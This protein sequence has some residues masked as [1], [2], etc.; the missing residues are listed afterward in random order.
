MN[1]RN[2]SETGLRIPTEDPQ[3]ALNFCRELTR[4]L[5]QNGFSRFGVHSGSEISPQPCLTLVIPVLNEAENLNAL[6][7]S[8]I[9]VLEGKKLSFEIIF[10]DDGST[11]AGPG[12]LAELSARDARVVVVELARNF[13]QQTAFSA[14]LSYARGQAVILMDA[15]LQDT[16]EAIPKF[17]E[18][19][20]EGYDVVYAVRVERKEPPVLRA[21]YMMFYRLLKLTSN[22]EIP[23]NA[24]DFCLM[25]QKVAQV[26][27]SMPERNRFVRGIRSWAGFRQTGINVE[28]RARFA[29]RPKYSIRGLTL[30]AIDGLVSFSLVP[31]RCISFMGLLVSVLALCL[32]VFYAVKK[33]LYGLHPYG[34]ATTVVLICFLAGVQLITIGVIGEYVGRIFVEVKQ[35][36]LFVVRRVIRAKEEEGAG[37]K[38]PGPQSGI[39]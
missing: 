24:G 3:A 23:L 39:S 20:R 21:A 29:G 1:E 26:L 7:S 33:M 17:I 12:I 6:Y 22:I 36:P 16:P 8:I 15:D 25:D 30:L 2:Q 28:R 10:V 31:L 19:W 11:D 5:S 37:A 32:T 14:G 13:G 27:C 34:F 18:K 9:T 4:L 38:G 35:R